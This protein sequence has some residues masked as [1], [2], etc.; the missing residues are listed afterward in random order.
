MA[1]KKAK[2]APPKTQGKAREGRRTKVAKNTLAI[3]GSALG[4]EKLDGAVIQD[5]LFRVTEKK[6]PVCVL[7]QEL[8]F[9][10]V[11]SLLV[12]QPKPTATIEASM[13]FQ[14]SE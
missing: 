7:I 10:Q 3:I 2:K 12:I 11:G 4:I 13:G 6:A 8:E 5:C 9:R 14:P 1:G